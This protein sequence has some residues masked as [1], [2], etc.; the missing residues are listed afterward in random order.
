MNE[1]S[2]LKQGQAPEAELAAAIEALADHVVD[3]PG[4]AGDSRH[5]LA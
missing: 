3:P 4:R 5:P 2:Q 1:D